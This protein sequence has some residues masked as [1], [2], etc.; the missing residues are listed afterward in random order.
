MRVPARPLRALAIVAAAVALASG[1]HLPGASLPAILRIA[2]AGVATGLVRVDLAKLQQA[3]GARQ[4]QVAGVPNATEVVLN[5]RLTVAGPGISGT[6]SAAVPFVPPAAGSTG[7][8]AA[9]TLAVPAGANRIFTLEGLNA[10]GQPVRRLMAAAAVVGGEPVALEMTYLSDAVARVIDDL[11]RRPALSA[12]EAAAFDALTG[13]QLQTALVGTQAPDRAGIAAKLGTTDFVAPLTAHVDAVVGYDAGTNAFTATDPVHFRAR[14]LANL[15]RLNGL[16]A[17]GATPDPRL[18]QTS[19]ATFAVR[20]LDS[21]GAA[22]PGA[23]VLLFAPRKAFGA[24]KTPGTYEFVGVP[25]GTWVVAASYGATTVYRSVNVLDGAPTGTETLT[26]PV[27]APTP[28][29]TP[30]PTPDIKTLAVG[31]APQDVAIDAGGGVWISSA[32]TDEVIKL[33]PDGSADAAYAT[34]GDQ[35]GAIAFDPAGNLWG[36]NVAGAQV[37]KI[38]PTG[39]LLGAFAVG[40]APAA[41]AFDA[42]GNAWIPNANDDTVSKLSPTGSPLGTFAVGDGPRDVAIDANGYAWVV[43]ALANTVTKLS[44][45]GSPLGTYAVGTGPRSVAIDPGGSAWVSNQAS[46]N[47][48]KLDA[49]GN[50]TDTFPLSGG[51]DGLVIGGGGVV[52]VSRPAAQVVTRL[53]LVG[54]ELATY[55]VGAGAANLAVDGAGHGWVVNATDGTVTRIVP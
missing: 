41:I 51:P 44:A 15:V 35:P 7:P 3:W 21:A 52:W 30:V 20:V 9:L 23:N 46:N 4:L 45:S 37:T 36:A 48:V 50:L 27:A 11:V 24:E 32:G 26:L 47:V 18:A 31:T 10:D 13:D 43:N 19:A 55:P 8:V 1:C 49:A 5:L 53:S 12:T 28:T 29:P 14:L 34:I 40:N 6:A 25:A 22:F 54:S 2:P 16:P 39:S 17:A 33:K 38:G 42:A